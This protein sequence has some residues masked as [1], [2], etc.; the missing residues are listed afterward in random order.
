MGYSRRACLKQT[1]KE[2]GGKG[3]I[4]DNQRENL[5]KALYLFDI[6]LL[7]KIKRLLSVRT[8]EMG[9]A[10]VAYNLSHGKD[11]TELMQKS[12]KFKVSLGNRVQCLPVQLSKSCS[13]IQLK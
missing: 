13:K 12:H 9:T 3:K 7:F 4:K 1:N 6:E 8:V 10:A 11:C 5:C 2:K